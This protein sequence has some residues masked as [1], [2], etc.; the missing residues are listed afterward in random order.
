MAAERLPAAQAVTP[1]HGIESRLGPRGAPAAPSAWSRL[2]SVS[3]GNTEILQNI[4]PLF[5]GAVRGS[6]GRL[7]GH[8]EGSQAP[9]RRTAQVC[10]YPQTPTQ[11]HAPQRCGGPGA[12][13]RCG[14]PPSTRGPASRFSPLRPRLRRQFPSSPSSL[15]CTTSS[16]PRPTA[17]CANAGWTKLTI[18]LA[19]SLLLS[20]QE[21]GSPPP[22]QG[23]KPG[24]AGAFA[25]A[26]IC[27]VAWGRDLPR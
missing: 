18:S 8:L 23:R 3:L 10:I 19:N 12:T 1:G 2:L 5:K 24:I 27:P 16:W 21:H 17:H 7:P 26:L 11:V 22:R 6:G 9:P 4:A 25:P 20:R 14:L 13:A 15:C